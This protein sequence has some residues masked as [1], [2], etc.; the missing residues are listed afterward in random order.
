MMKI[1]FYHVSDCHL[2]EDMGQRLTALAA[3]LGFEIVPINIET[4]ED[5]CERY[6][7]KIPLLVLDGEEICYH[8]LD[9]TEFRRRL[10]AK[11]VTR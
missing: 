7:L 3:E 4:D 9:E 2:C 1:H 11:K 8:R 6:G 5:L 10:G